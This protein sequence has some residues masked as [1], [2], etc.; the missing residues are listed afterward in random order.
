MIVLCYDGSACAKHAITCAHAT[1]GQAQA[2][3][4]HIWEP[5]ESYLG[6]DPF[7]QIAEL[8]AV[9]SE[10]A[11]RTLGYGVELAR[12]AG[13]E[14]EGRLERSSLT[15]WRTILDVAEESDAQLIVVGARG[16]SALESLLLG[17]VSS[18][19]VHHSTRPTLVVPLPASTASDDVER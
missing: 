11:K 19:L 2:L 5:P 16:H 6:P 14:V 18:A 10:R 3:L 4:L 15:V 9:A 1:I 17:D 12:E 7:P 8:E 13:F